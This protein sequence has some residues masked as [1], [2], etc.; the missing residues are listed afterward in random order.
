MRAAE[1]VLGAVRMTAAAWKRTGIAIGD[2]GGWHTAAELLA[3]QDLS[4]QQVRLMPQGLPE[5][6]NVPGEM[7][8][9]ACAPRGDRPDRGLVHGRSRAA[10]QANAGAAAFLCSS[11]VLLS[12]FLA[13]AW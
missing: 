11:P 7:C 1:A 5:R 12:A 6:I 10:P 9:C 4:L 13:R 3:R 2:A 8:D